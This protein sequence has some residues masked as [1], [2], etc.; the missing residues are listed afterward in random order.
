[1]NSALRLWSQGHDPKVRSC[2]AVRDVS[3]QRIE[4]VS[5]P[6]NPAPKELKR[7]PAFHRRCNRYP[8]SRLPH[9][10]FAS[11]GPNTG[12]VRLIKAKGR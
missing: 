10:P 2:P 12:F 3:E 4:K 9:L 1:V 6:S 7:E 8:P 11:S 5:R